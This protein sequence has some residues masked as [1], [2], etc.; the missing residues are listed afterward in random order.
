MQIKNTSASLVEV[1]ANASDLAH[2]ILKEASQQARIPVPIS[3]LPAELSKRMSDYDLSPALIA[4]QSGVSVNTVKKALS[5][6]ENM[7]VITL[8][9]IIGPLGLSLCFERQ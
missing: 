9:K 1:L 4:A 2:S 8:T 5:D 7:K 3:E 6:P